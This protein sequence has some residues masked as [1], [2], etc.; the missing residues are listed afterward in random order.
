[1]SSMIVQNEKVH[2]S[3]QNYQKRNWERSRC[4]LNDRWRE[5]PLSQFTSWVWS[6][7]PRSR[8]KAYLPMIP[9]RRT[10]KKTETSRSRS[11]RQPR[12]HQWAWENLSGVHLPQITGW[13]EPLFLIKNNYFSKQFQLPSRELSSNMF[14]SVRIHESVHYWLASVAF[15]NACD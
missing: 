14:I 11:S 2:E 10:A 6:E 4:S 9:S 7:N 1:M 8:R 13:F 3:S 15:R 12:D 5:F